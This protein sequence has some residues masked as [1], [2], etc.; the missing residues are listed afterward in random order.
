MEKRLLHD[1]VVAPIA[2]FYLYPGCTLENGTS[3]HDAY[4]AGGPC[5]P[6]TLDPDS[7]GQV[8]TGMAVDAWMFK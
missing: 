7:H 4:S 1:R 8:A 5:L 6:E 2:A 3:Y